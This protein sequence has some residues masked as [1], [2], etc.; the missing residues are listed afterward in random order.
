MH[1]TLSWSGYMI[2]SI[3][4]LVPYLIIF[5]LIICGYIFT[6][7]DKNNIRSI[8][9]GFAV[10]GFLFGIFMLF[11]NI[12]YV[13]TDLFLLS[14]IITITSLLYLRCRNS[15]LS[16]KLDFNFDL[17]QKNDMIIQI[18]YYIC[19][20]LA[21]IIYSRSE[22]YYR[23]PFF[24]IVISI[25]IALLGL[26]IISV[27]L[28]VK[29]VYLIITNILILSFMLRYTGYF[30]SPYPVGSD[31][32]MHTEYIKNFLNYQHIMV[33][34]GIYEVNNFYTR[35]PMAHLLSCIFILIGN[36]TVKQSWFICGIT[37]LFSTLFTF[38]IV[39]K[40][41]NSERLALLSMLFI[42]FTDC[43]LEWGIQI[44]AMSFGLAIYSII[45]Y[46][47]FEKNDKNKQIFSC[48]LV[49][50][51]FV[52]IWSHTISAF[53]SLIVIFLFLIMPLVYNKI[54]SENYYLH[55]KVPFTLISLFIVL[56][57]FHWMDS[58]YPFFDMSIERL[59]IS[60]KSEAGF[61]DAISY[62]NII[63]RPEAIFD[64]I[65]FLI[66]LTFGI[67]GTLYFISKKHANK[68]MVSLI[69]ISL[70]LYVVRYGFPIL[71]MRT[72]IPDRW[73]A[74]A[75]IS[76]IPLVTVGFSLLLNMFGSKNKQICFTLIILLISSFFMISNHSSNIDSPIF[77]KETAQK[78]LWTS[79][80][81]TLITNINNSYN[82][83]IITDLQTGLR[84]YRTY[85]TRKNVSYYDLNPEKKY[86]LNN[87]NCSAV[88]IWRSSNLKRP[89]VVNVHGERTLMLLG[90]DFQNNLDYDFNCI[91]DTKG[92]K[93]YFYG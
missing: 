37:L 76:F 60:L 5:T 65:G 77:S 21:L 58:G 67:I 83:P 40:I 63:E 52:I 22:P 13:S 53:I 45:L 82:G 89:V 30:I 72:V 32:W 42:N 38:L 39:K 31:P 28:S 2:N 54:Y 62:S 71:G 59:M 10:V 34:P 20:I 88:L 73:S 36:V 46:L 79:S 25:A 87:V 56:L 70:S 14:P 41:T 19:F 92:A 44:I 24:F 48:L 75:S 69:F 11:M 4:E 84:P 78:D 18:M 43:N 7:I 47:L 29:R 8:D 80:E 68:Y 85:L 1:D 55:S 16:S 12:I 9:G 74:F 50:Y 81:M 57:T 51:A 15:I 64:S 26:E 93:A 23:P 66:H 27:K 33:T 91:Y 35:F 86:A 61:L 17:G 3:N 90:V 6:K 49:L